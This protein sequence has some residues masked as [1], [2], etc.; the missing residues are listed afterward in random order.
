MSVLGNSLKDHIGKQV[1]VV[2]IDRGAYLGTLVEFDDN[3]IALENIYESST[4]TALTWHRVVL[5]GP[6]KI[7]PEVPMDEEEAA[8][9][10]KLDRVLISLRNVIR[11]WPISKKI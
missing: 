7:D 5:D 1:I 11:I 6:M 3:F 8:V 10:L 2:T 4:E 9:T